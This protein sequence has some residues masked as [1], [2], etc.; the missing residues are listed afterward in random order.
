MRVCSLSLVHGNDRKD[1]LKTEHLSFLF[2]LSLESM[3]MI[4]KAY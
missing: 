1:L 2:S 4:S 3:E